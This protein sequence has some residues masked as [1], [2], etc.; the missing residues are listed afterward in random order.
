MKVVSCST[1]TYLLTY[2]GR[3]L[4]PTLSCLLGIFWMCQLLCGILEFVCGC[5]LSDKPYTLTPTLIRNGNVTG[6]LAVVV[7]VVDKLSIGVI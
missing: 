1:L 4:L 2:L 5:L 7:V 6:K 3:Y